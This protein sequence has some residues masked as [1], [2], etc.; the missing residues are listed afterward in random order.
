MLTHFLRAWAGF[1]EAKSM[2][3]GISVP[4]ETPLELATRKLR[5]SAPQK[6]KRLKRKSTSTKTYFYVFL[7]N[8]K[9]LPR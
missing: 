7:I 4:G 9:R 1:K 6:D 3:W 2:S 8:Q 5:L